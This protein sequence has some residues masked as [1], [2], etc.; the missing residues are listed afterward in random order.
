MYFSFH[1]Y[2]LPAPYNRY[3]IYHTTYTESVCSLHI[4]VLLISQLIYGFFWVQSKFQNSPLA[5][6]NTDVYTIVPYKKII[7]KMPVPVEESSFYRS[8]QYLKIVNSHDAYGILRWLLQSL[9]QD[10]LLTPW[11]GAPS[12]SRH[13]ICALIFFSVDSTWSHSF[14]FASSAPGTRIC[15]IKHSRHPVARLEHLQFIGSSYTRQYW[16]HLS[17]KLE[18]GNVVFISGC[19]DLLYMM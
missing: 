16:T 3:Y 18:Y 14:K 12:S 2:P 19:W 6:P 8:H 7:L 9:S 1:V 11:L 10:L 5:S 15:L 13:F 4:R 17:F